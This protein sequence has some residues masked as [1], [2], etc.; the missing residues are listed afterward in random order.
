MCDCHLS[1]PRGQ[2]I[3]CMGGQL[4]S[5][6]PN[7]LPIFLE[8]LKNEITRLTTVRVITQIAR[9]DDV[10]VGSCDACFT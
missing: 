3:S 1:I 4:S 7:C 9:Y 10:I 5:E 6:L 8:R 2:V